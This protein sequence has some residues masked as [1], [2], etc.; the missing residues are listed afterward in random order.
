MAR[1]LSI[2]TYPQKQ[3]SIKLLKS[4]VALRIATDFS[5]R[6]KK[7]DFLEKSD[8]SPRVKKSDFLEKSDF[9][10]QVKKSDFLEKSDFSPRVKKSDFLKKSDFSPRVNVLGLQQRERS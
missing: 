9:S 8:F 5:P 4:G 3:V 6:V 1:Q 2:I 7:S 10:P